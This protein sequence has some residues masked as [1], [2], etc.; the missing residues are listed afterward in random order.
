MTKRE[1]EVKQGNNSQYFE[2]DDDTI[3]LSSLKIYYPEISG[4]TYI[5]NGKFFCALVEGNNLKCAPG[6]DTYHVFAKKGKQR[7]LTHSA[8]NV[9]Q[10]LICFITIGS[11]SS[12][13]T[14]SQVQKEKFQSLMNII[15][16]KAEQDKPKDVE[17]RK[18]INEK[19]TPTPA[20]SQKSS[21]KV[22]VIWHHRDDEKQKWYKG[23]GETKEIELFKNVDYSVLEVKMMCIAAYKN[24]LNANYFE[25]G[26][27]DIGR[28]NFDVIQDF[29]T[30]GFWS[31]WKSACSKAHRAVTLYMYTYLSERS[32]Q[33]DSKKNESIS[34]NIL[35]SCKSLYNK[36]IAEEKKETVV[37]SQVTDE[38]A[39]VQPKPVTSFS[40]P[41]K[42][43]FSSPND[44]V[45]SETPMQSFITNDHSAKL[46]TVLYPSSPK[47]RTQF[48]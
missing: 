26:T 41:K 5:K 24:I 1:I 19:K 40:T 27:V 20:L 28:K 23:P 15:V 22:Q 33:S 6:V 34:L 44:L 12:P 8:V 18:K 4:L 32:A 3:S 17:K 29:G 35:P 9:N 43:R 14:L 21:V 11:A 25:K 38:H 45:Q 2:V 46:K 37:K 10:V 39:F 47:K 30:G 7:L 16:N 13:A 42:M 48:N 31:F 36:P